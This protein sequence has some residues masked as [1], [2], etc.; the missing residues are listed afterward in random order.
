MVNINRLFY[1]FQS[2]NSNDHIEISLFGIDFINA[3]NGRLESLRNQ[4]NNYALFNGLKGSIN[5]V[6]FKKMSVSE[7]KK[8]TLDFYNANLKGKKVE[9]KNYLKEVLFVTDAGRKILKPI[10][11]EKVAIIEHLE[12]LIKNS[13]YN[14]FGERKESDSKD[15]L[16][17]LNFKS[18]ITIDGIKRHVRISIVLDRDRKTKLKTFEVGKKEKSG[19]SHEV[20]VTNPKDGEKKPLSTNKG[21]KNNSKKTKPLKGIVENL[22]VSS[23]LGEP[24]PIIKTPPALINT[25]AYRL[26]N[27]SNIPHEY[28][29][30]PDKDISN[31]LGKIEKKNKESVAITITGSQ[32][33]MKTRLCFQLMNCFAQNYKV[34][35]ASIEEHPES[36][37]YT[38]KMSQ[39]L[40]DKALHNISAP[41]INNIQDVH[42]LVKENDVIFIDSFSKLQEMQRGCALDKDFR[43]AYDGKLFIIIYQQTTDGKMRGGSKSQFDGDIICFIEKEDNYQ[44]NYCYWDKNRYQNA[45][46]GKLQFNIFDG[47]LVQDNLLIEDEIT[48]EIE[49][50]FNFNVL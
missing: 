35:H 31:F 23:I 10:Y 42:N 20:A 9:I 46:P 33:S 45:N 48:N 44:D 36:S 39:Y 16:G 2:Y 29:I 41:E 14:N 49:H 15:I 21:N 25:L 40:N 5:T 3:V 13:T 24:E 6:E 37:L 8:F 4:K 43:K 47:K 34:G 18:K 12:D 38:D 27:K 22:I 28:Y 11:S 7:L 19:N 17:F 26:Q 50:D 1:I 32:G 30:I